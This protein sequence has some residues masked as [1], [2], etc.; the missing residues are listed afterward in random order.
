MINDSVARV[1]NRCFPPTLGLP[2]GAE[3]F[4]DIYRDKNFDFLIEL[5][6]CFDSADCDSPEIDFTKEFIRKIRAS[7]P[8]ESREEFVMWLFSHYLGNPLVY[9]YLYGIDQPLAETQRKLKESNL[10]KLVP[11]VISSGI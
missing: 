9:R 7:I 11:I 4:C 3:V 1:L 2:G 8:V 10:T 5:A 6:R